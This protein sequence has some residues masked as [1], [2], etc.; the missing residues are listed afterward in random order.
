[1]WRFPTDL[2]TGQLI[3]ARSGGVMYWFLADAPGQPARLLH[4]QA[5]PKT[6]VAAIRLFVD[7]R[8]ITTQDIVDITCRDM[9]LRTNE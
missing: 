7:Y 8:R 1:M 3:L 6:E 9:T 4:R 2:R 5:C